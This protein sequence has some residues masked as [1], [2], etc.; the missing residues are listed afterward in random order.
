MSWSN[1]GQTEINIVLNCR[2][3]RSLCHGTCGKRRFL[4]HER[5]H[6]FRQRFAS[7]MM[8]K[9]SAEAAAIPGITPKK[10]FEEEIEALVLK[11]HDIKPEKLR[12][13]Q[14]LLDTND[15]PILSVEEARRW[16]ERIRKAKSFTCSGD[17][18]APQEA[19]LATCT[20]SEVLSLIPANET[21]SCPRD[22]PVVAF[23]TIF[24]A[25]DELS[26][27]SA[28]SLE[29]QQ[30]LLTTFW[31]CA[32]LSNLSPTME[33]VYSTVQLR[34]YL[35]YPVE[36]ILK[37]QSPAFGTLS[38]TYPQEAMIT[39]VVQLARLYAAWRGLPPSLPSEALTY[40]VDNILAQA[41][42]SLRLDWQARHQFGADTAYTSFASFAQEVFMT[43]F[44]HTCGDASTMLGQWLAELLSRLHLFGNRSAVRSA[45][46]R[47]LYAVGFLHR[48]IFSPD[49]GTSVQCTL[50]ARVTNFFETHLS[51]E[52]SAKLANS[53][54]HYPDCLARAAPATTERFKLW[55]L[56]FYKADAVLSQWTLRDQL[57][58]HLPTW[59]SDFKKNSPPPGLAPA[60]PRPE[61][62]CVV[63]RA[64][65]VGSDTQPP[66]RIDPP[67]TL[68]DDHG[69]THEFPRN[70][71]A[72]QDQH[73]RQ[74]ILDLYLQCAASPSRRCSVCQQTGHVVRLCPRLRRVDALGLE[75]RPQS[76]FLQA[77]AAAS[78]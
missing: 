9:T 64:E 69:Q 51:S 78:A 47:T 37:D 33:W 7:I 4:D 40:F 44:P 29:L 8:Q 73:E 36:S 32:D 31:G 74:A 14:K 49:D 70:L 15:D 61:A 17:T 54:Q 13:H 62:V 26:P 57:Y 43:R 60:D 2:G 56:T 30:S 27:G 39:F 53:L 55:P 22:A 72:I 59:L 75:T 6:H 67:F 24:K 34:E 68:R 63:S 5:S 20:S 28:L 52:V 11:H 38:S 65:S 58:A 46:R 10:T 3:S 42:P 71:A 45:I 12:N 25:A 19:V 16:I 50:D 18:I 23:P 66:P 77:A 48:V 21:P 76:F 1:Q 41:E 35:Q